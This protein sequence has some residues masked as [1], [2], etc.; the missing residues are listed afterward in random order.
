ME[1]LNISENLENTVTDRSIEAALQLGRHNKYHGLSLS[2]CEKYRPIKEEDRYPLIRPLPK[3]SFE[4]KKANLGFR[5]THVYRICLRFHDLDS[6]FSESKPL[7]LSIMQRSYFL[8]QNR[9][10]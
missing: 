9:F 3:A 6:P 7:R 2:R 10:A 4:H 8:N 1:L 5:G